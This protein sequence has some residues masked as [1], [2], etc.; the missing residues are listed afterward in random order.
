MKYSGFFAGLTTIDIQY[1]VDQFPESNKKLKTAAPDILVGGPATNAA[2]AFSHLNGGACLASATGKNPF[3]TYIGDDFLQNKVQ[4]YNFT[5]SKKSNPV[6]ATV[7]TSGINGDRTIFTHHPGPIASELDVGELIQQVNPQIILLDGFY[8]E[9]TVELA[10]ICN[11]KNVPVVL[12]CGSWKPQYEILVPLADIVICSNDFFPPGC[13]SIN[14]VVDFLHN[15]GV[16]KA[17]VSRGADNLVF[18]DS[19]RRGEL[20]VEKTNIVDTL[21]AGDFLHGAFCFYFLDTNFQ[22]EE[23]LKQAV[24]FA[25]FTCKF[26][27][28][29]SWINNINSYLEIAE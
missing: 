11:L 2:I 21:G 17:A 23:A 25:T 13:G 3:S 9:A 22:F 26:K 20:P 24:N 8:P 12:D 18:V 19:G 16:K 27:G 14:E 15:S 29:R 28:T 1:F 4:Y 10:H 5:A 7:V 6:L